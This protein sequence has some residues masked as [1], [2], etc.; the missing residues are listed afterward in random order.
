M[1]KTK[2]RLVKLPSTEIVRFT[3]EKHSVLTRLIRSWEQERLVKFARKHKEFFVR[4]IT[5]F[6]PLSPLLIQ[7]HDNFFLKQP[8]LSIL[9]NNK[10]IASESKMCF[11]MNM[12]KIGK[13]DWRGI[14]GI[15]NF[16]WTVQLI[17]QHKDKWR[18]RLMN[19]NAGLPWSLEFLS[20]FH[21]YWQWNWLSNNDMQGQWTL[22]M[23][24]EHAEHIDWEA[25]SLNKGLPW[26]PQLIE[27][28]RD[29]W[30]WKA[31]SGNDA[32]PWTLELYENYQN[33]AD[34]C[35]LAANKSFPWTAELLERFENEF[36]NACCITWNN[37]VYSATRKNI[38]RNGWYFL[39]FNPKITWTQYLFDR[40]KPD[41]EKN[42]LW[43]HGRLSANVPF[44][45]Y[46]KFLRKGDFYSAHD[47]AHNTSMPWS[48]KL[49]KK[50]FWH[51]GVLSGNEQIIWTIDLLERY[52]DQ[53]NWFEE[54][55]VK[56]KWF[57]PDLETNSAVYSKAFKPFLTDEIIDEILQKFHENG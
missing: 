23:I 57:N 35:I 28:Y 44:R 36:D 4:L 20:R 8:Y 52:A 13:W 51:F 37:K 40:Y 10:Y 14:S 25:F 7:K 45:I 16:P 38:T 46:R 26:S 3:T 34:I 33:K 47:M 22:E 32:I 27:R 49:M 5:R 42:I 2:T 18:W 1:A 41:I 9:L 48:E 12:D 17:E 30:N 54:E 50:Y 6:H 24:D 29:R 53:W 15:E 21:R 56:D 19:Q 11:A 39:S 31:L 43:V 55:W